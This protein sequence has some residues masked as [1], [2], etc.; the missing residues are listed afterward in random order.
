MYRGVSVNG[1]AWQV[2]IM[3]DSEKIYLC[4]LND[5]IKG[6]QLYDLAIIQAKGLNS[7]INFSYTKVQLLAILF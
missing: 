1:K 5:P 7:K 6:A 3:I 2:L 4:T